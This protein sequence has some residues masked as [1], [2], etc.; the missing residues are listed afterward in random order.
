MLFCFW[1]FLLFFVAQLGGM[2]ASPASAEQRAVHRP[3]TARV[4]RPTAK[5]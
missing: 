3:I 4:Y 5:P 2:I 1:S